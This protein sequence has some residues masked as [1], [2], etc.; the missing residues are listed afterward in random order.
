MRRQIQNLTENVTTLASIVNTEREGTG[1]DVAGPV[2]NAVSIKTF[3]ISIWTDL[4]YVAISN[5]K[6]THGNCYVP[7][8]YC[9]CYYYF[10]GRRLRLSGEC[11]CTTHAISP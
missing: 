7:D 11:A 1:E 8:S 6:C 3:P 4:T 2:H 5:L 9:Y 10:V